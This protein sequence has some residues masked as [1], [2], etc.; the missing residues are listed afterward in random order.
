MIGRD[1]FRE[2][3]RFGIDRRVVFGL[4]TFLEVAQSAVERYALLGFVLNLQVEVAEVV[5]PGETRFQVGVNG[6][7]EYSEEQG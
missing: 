4:H 2:C 7:D 1:Y 5:V 6:T 3:F